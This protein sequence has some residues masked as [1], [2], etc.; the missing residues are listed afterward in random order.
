[1]FSNGFHK[2]KYINFIAIEYG[3]VYNGDGNGL[4]VIPMTWV[5]STGG[6]HVSQA[7]AGIDF[8]QATAS[9]VQDMLKM[10]KDYKE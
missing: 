8:S 10:L 3:L 5:W 9:N 4:G 1:M 2:L 7:S 6:I